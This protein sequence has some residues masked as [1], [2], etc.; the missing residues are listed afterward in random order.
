MLGLKLVTDPRWATL[1]ESNIEN[2]LQTMRGVSKKQ[3]PTL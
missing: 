3:P 1:V 2:Y